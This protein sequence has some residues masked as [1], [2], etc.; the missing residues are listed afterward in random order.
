MAIVCRPNKNEIKAFTEQPSIL[1]PSAESTVQ[2]LQRLALMIRDS[3]CWSLAQS[4]K[5]GR[6]VTEIR[7]VEKLAWH[8]EDYLGWCPIS[9]SGRHNWNYS[10]ASYFMFCSYFICYH[11]NWCFIKSSSFPFSRMHLAI[12]NIS[13]YYLHNLFGNFDLL[14]LKI[15][16]TL[17]NKYSQ[18]FKLEKQ[19]QSRGLL[20]SGGGTWFTLA[21]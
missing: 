2:L 5:E 4:H 6:G 13:F 20:G 14:V 11:I 7:K 12:L 8:F 18:G 3:F 10:L 9:S 19:P 16:V 21:P 15:V 1:L 17:P